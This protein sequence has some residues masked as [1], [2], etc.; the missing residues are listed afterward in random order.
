MQKKQLIQFSMLLV[1]ILILAG[2]YAGIRSYN[3][4]EEKKIEQQEADAKITLTSFQPKRITD[5]SYDFD[6]TQ[7]TFSNAQGEWKLSENTEMVLDQEKFENFLEDAG[8]L[9]A[10][11]EIEPEAIDD[12]EDYGFDNPLRTV[13]VTTEKG[14][15]S[16]T[17]GMKNEMLGQYYLKTSESSRIYLVEE[18]VYTVFDKTAEDF[19]KEEEEET[20]TDTDEQDI[21]ME[22]EDA[23]TKSDE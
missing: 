21:D 4:N 19:E 1:L 15:S 3:S 5:I 6:G 9:T 22:G 7:Y 18:S 17:F 13:S 11:Q 16:L 12:E 23:Q 10:V 2:A 14:T 8:S 20:Q